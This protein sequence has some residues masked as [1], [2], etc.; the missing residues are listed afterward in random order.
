MIDALIKRVEG[1]TKGR[2]SRETGNMGYTRWRQTKQKYNTICVGHHYAFCCCPIMSFFGLSF[3]LWCSLRF[4][5]KTMFNSSLPPTVCRRLMSYLR[6]LCVLCIVVSNTYCVVF[7]LCLS[8][9]CVPHVASFSGLSTF[10]FM[11]KS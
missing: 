3:L 2:Q 11:R 7:L 8:S 9:S 5:H 6:Y 10:S 4:P 1:G